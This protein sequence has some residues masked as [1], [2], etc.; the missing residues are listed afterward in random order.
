M[1]SP[2]YAKVALEEDGH[3]GCDPRKD[4]DA[5][6]HYLN[7][8]LVFGKIRPDRRPHR[9]GHLPV[10]PAN[11]VDCTRATQ[12]QSRHVKHW[13]AAAIIGRELQKT[14][15]AFS[16]AVPVAGQVTLYEIKW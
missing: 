6:R 2:V 1:L 12:G 10:D 4:M 11:S 14:V 13:A 9:A 15:T 3:V 5:V 16:E 7:R 8:T